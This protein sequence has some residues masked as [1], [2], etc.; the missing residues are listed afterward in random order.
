MK[1]WYEEI[2]V[3]LTAAH[4]LSIDVLLGAM[5][6]HR[7]ALHLPEGRLGGGGWITTLLV[8]IAVFLIYTTD[9]LLDNLKTPRP[10]THRHRFY[11]QNRDWLLK[12]VV[13]LGV[14]GLGLLFWLPSSVWCVGLG[15]AVVVGIYLWVVYR[16][17]SDHSLIV[18]KEIVVAVAYTVG[19][20]GTAIVQL[21]TISWEAWSLMLMVGLI[22]FQNLL[23]F[24]WFE[25]LEVER[26]YSMVIA[27]GTE[28]VGNWLNKWPILVGLGAV[29]VVIFTPYWYCVRVSFMLLMMSLALFWI[30]KEANALLSN[31]HYRWLS[32]GVFFLGL[33]VLD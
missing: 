29:V 21:P 12:I 5:L 30:K 16:L 2:A 3:V 24:G 7:V 19:V 4:W 20:W 6:M 1:R 10:V 14:I 31:E 22:A 25:S 18:Y 15:L 13:G 26:G 33:W 32:D 23:L 17:P 9:R 11:A 27:W 28:S 8:G